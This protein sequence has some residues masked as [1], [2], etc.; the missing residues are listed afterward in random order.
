MEVQ[1]KL[2]TKAGPVYLTASDKGLTGVWWK[3]QDVPM[4]KDTKTMA[5]KYLRQA[6]K[7]L[8][9]YFEGQR[10]KFQ[11]R[12]DVDGTD[13]Q[14]RVWRQLCQIPYGK[15]RSYADI[16]AKIKNE[17]AVRAVGAANGR[18]PLSIIVP[19]HRVIGSGGGLTGYAGGLEAKKKLLTL[20]G[21]I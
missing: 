16:A 9:E 8:N 6:E 10:Q 11:V 17:K 3:A 15:T 19:C 4:L 21:C 1:M 13:F 20:E 12:L 5:A 14:K 7:E 2:R 18:N